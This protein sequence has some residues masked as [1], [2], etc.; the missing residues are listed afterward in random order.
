MNNND[1]P[2]INFSH[3]SCTLEFSVFAGFDDSHPYFKK[4][5]DKVVLKDTEELEKLL[6]VI[7]KRPKRRIEIPN[8]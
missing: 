4:N 8:D 5:I 6:Q 1:T 7:P 2:K 3:L